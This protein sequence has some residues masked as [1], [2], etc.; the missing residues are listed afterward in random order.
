MNVLLID[1]ASRLEIIAACSES[2][3][4]D[5]SGFVDTS[6]SPAILDNVDRCLK[7]LGIPIR[8]VDL[9]GVGTGPGSFTGIRIAVSTCRMLAQVLSK[10]LVGIKTQLLYAVSVDAVEGDNILIAFDAKKNRVFGA[11]YKKSG[12][13]LRPREIIPPG[14]YPIKKLL[15]S[16]D[17]SC[18]THMAG[19][20]IEKYL[21]LIE[22]GVGKRM[23]L[24]DF[25]PDGAIMCDLVRRSYRENP[26]MYADYNRIIPFYA[27]KSDAEEAK[28]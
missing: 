1:T 6:H 24:N 25:I 12:D 2:G 28:G 10:P 22:Y 21:T 14:D 11:L 26:E 17:K 27:R 23:V 13:T 19:S 16:I 18:M 9:I 7:K 5:V 4:V 3:P 20:G 8:D 15:D